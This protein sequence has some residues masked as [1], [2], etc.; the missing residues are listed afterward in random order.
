MQVFLVEVDRIAE[1]REI[2]VE[3]LSGRALWGTSPLI[4]FGC[5][6]Q[7]WEREGTTVYV[8]L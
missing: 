2:S 8:F 1:S 5:R 6:L 3:F 7:G 4:V